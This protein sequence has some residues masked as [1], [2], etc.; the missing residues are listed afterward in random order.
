MT[1]IINKD[2]K[3]IVE[4]KYDKLTCEEGG[5]IK[6]TNIDGTQVIIKPNN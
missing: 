3:L 6:A 1:G 2:G 4:V 5:V